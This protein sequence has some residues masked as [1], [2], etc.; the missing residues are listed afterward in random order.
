MN[1]TTIETLENVSVGSETKND[2]QEFENE[3]ICFVHLISVNIYAIS[4]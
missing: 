3:P 4:K 2:F 1:T